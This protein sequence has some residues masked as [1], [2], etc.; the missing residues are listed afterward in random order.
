MLGQDVA[1]FV[2]VGDA[3]NWSSPLNRGLVSWWMALPDQ[4]RGNILRDLCGKHPGTLTSGPTVQGPRGRRGGFGSTGFGGD[5][6]YV[7][8]PNHARLNPAQFTA[9]CW[10]RT[11][12]ATTR[13][14]FFGKG[15]G[16]GG[17]ATAWWLE[18]QSNQLLTLVTSDVTSI[19]IAGGA[20]ISGVWHHVAVTFDGVTVRLYLDGVQVASTALAGS[21]VS[22]TDPIR[23][24]EALTGGF[25]LGLTG[26]MADCT[27]FSR[28]LSAAEI[29]ARRQDSIR[30]YP[31]TLNWQYPPLYMLTEEVGGGFIDNTNPIW[32][33][34]LAA[35][36]L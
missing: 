5:N 12:D 4:P 34:L 8:V 23:M 7:E 15:T 35:G 6:I 32:R 28:P 18:I 30:G 25:G 21:L 10:V 17:A 24:G 33:H 1:G 27:F 29:Y 36:G 22:P 26:S 3:V 11:D 14:V 13:Q 19:Y 20:L 31:T 2:P 16:G 9:A